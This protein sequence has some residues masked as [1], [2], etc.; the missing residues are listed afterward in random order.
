[1]CQDHGFN[2][3]HSKP[4]N[5]ATFKTYFPRFVDSRKAHPGEVETTHVAQKGR[6][7]ILLV[8]DDELVRNMTADALLFLGYT[9]VTAANAQDAL[10]VRVNLATPIDLVIS[11]VVM[12]GMQGTD[13]GSGWSHFVP[14]LAEPSQLRA[15]EAGMPFVFNEGIP[16][17][18]TT[19]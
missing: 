6:G 2:E 18:S 9:P 12:P 4:G 3:V 16:K 14:A 10:E 15:S 8:E 1:V 13:Y 19:F 5:G 7:T 11:D 17:V